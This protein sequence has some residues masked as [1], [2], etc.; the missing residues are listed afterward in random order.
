LH[1]LFLL[2]SLI[3]KILLF[4]FFFFFFFF[5][6]NFFFNC[7]FFFFFFFFFF[8][9][10]FL[11]FFFFFFFFIFLFVFKFCCNGVNFWGS[12]GCWFILFAWFCAESTEGSSAIRCALKVRQKSRYSGRLWFVILL[13][14]ALCLLVCVNGVNV[15]SFFFFS[16]NAR[17]DKLIVI[18]K[19]KV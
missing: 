1:V 9:F 16:A 11:I 7:V 19:W 12:Y 15:E 5:V 18:G 3:F 10:F 4:F 14:L 6:F 2:H 13:L 8:I 17:I